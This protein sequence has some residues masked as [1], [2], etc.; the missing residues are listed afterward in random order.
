MQVGVAQVPPF[1]WQDEA[2]FW[3]GLAVQLWRD[4][5]DELDLEYDLVA[6]DPAALLDE[7]AQGSLDVGLTAVA[8][9]TAETRL[10]FTPSYFV[11]SLGVARP[12]GQSLWR[13]AQGLFTLRFLR[14]TLSLALLLLVVGVLIWL[15]ERRSNEDQFGGDS[16]LEG[17]GNSFW[18]AGVTMTTIGYGDKAPVTF[19]G[20]ALALL[21]MLVAMGVTASLTAA[22][23]S[24]VGASESSVS[25]P[26]DLREWQVGGVADTI[27]ARYLGEQ[28]IEF[29]TFEQPLEGLQALQRG[30]LEAFVAPAAT[31][32]FLVAEN[33][34]LTARVTTTD[35][36]PQR[37]T[38]AL[39]EDNE[40]RESLSE[41]VLR[42]LNS[43]SWS[44][45]VS[46][47]LPQGER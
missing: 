22:L 14:I 37:Y 29:Q 26:E 33:Q 32:N 27:G 42:R 3:D 6:A 1:A 38:F 25:I 45:V 18:W 46:R 16:A 24:V 28:G 8:T 47:Y 17:I 2:G 31:L 44:D 23:V 35:A 4:V 11:T 40:L 12:Q 34:D 43:A 5:A 19:G 21:W 30:D 13:I 7:V 10:D 39:A 9:A 41:Q 36:L 15:L 20:R